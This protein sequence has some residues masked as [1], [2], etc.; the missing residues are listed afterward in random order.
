[1]P[2]PP[3]SH[4]YVKSSSKG[5]YKGVSEDMVLLGASC[6][7]IREIEHEIDQLQA[8]LEVLRKKARKKCAAYKT[9]KA[10]PN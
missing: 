4:L 10:K 8:E 9:K 1:M 7:S 3:I 6:V 2:H 5:Q